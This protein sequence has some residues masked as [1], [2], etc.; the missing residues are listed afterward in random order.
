MVA[1]T[2][3]PWTVGPNG[4]SVRGPDNCTIANL[5]SLASTLLQRAANAHLIAAAPELLAAC[6]AQAALDAHPRVCSQCGCRPLR[7]VWHCGEYNRLRVETIKL[8]HLAMEKVKGGA[9]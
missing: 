1:H 2:A 4:I 8:R 6:E 7:E 3:A 5:P 9:T